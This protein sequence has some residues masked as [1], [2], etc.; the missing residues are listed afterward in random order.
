MPLPPLRICS[1]EPYAPLKQGSWLSAL[2]AHRGIWGV[3]LHRELEAVFHE[4][5]G[6]ASDPKIQEQGDVTIVL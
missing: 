3:D 6:S 2:A 1:S 4:P 5:T